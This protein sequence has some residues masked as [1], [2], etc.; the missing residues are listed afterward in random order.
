MRLII[1]GSE[2]ILK[3]I[4]K[5]AKLARELSDEAYKLRFVNSCRLSVLEET[6][7]AAATT[8]SEKND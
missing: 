2:E 3:T 8:E 7:L 5:I 1:E 4:E 6:D